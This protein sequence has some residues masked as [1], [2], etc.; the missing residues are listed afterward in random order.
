MLLDFGLLGLCDFDCIGGVDAE[1]NPCDFG[2]LGSG[3]DFSEQVM[4]FFIAETAFEYGCP[5]SGQ[6]VSHGLFLLFVRSLIS[7]G[8]ERSSDALLAAPGAVTVFG[9]DRVSL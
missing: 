3:A 7:F 8:L 1:E 2:W 5:H 6:S 9:I 4:I